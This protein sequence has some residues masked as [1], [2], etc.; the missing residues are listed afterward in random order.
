[1][2]LVNPCCLALSFVTYQKHVYCFVGAH[3]LSVDNDNAYEHGIYNLEVV[4]FQGHDEASIK[5]EFEGWDVRLGVDAR[6]L[7]DGKIKAT[8]LASRYLLITKPLERRASHSNVDVQQSETKDKKYPQI[9][10]AH[11]AARKQYSKDPQVTRI[12]LKFSPGDK[13]KGIELSN[14]FFQSANFDGD[15]CQPKKIATLS[16]TGDTNRTRDGSTTDQLQ[17]TTTVSWKL[18]NLKSEREYGAI[19]KKKEEKEEEEFDISGI[20]LNADDG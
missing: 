18:V 3:I 9:V 2:L 13:K 6:D 7:K 15:Y 19:Q 1:M 17:V 14:K 4:H 8:I 11:Q 20:D 12:V 16:K 5:R 10:K